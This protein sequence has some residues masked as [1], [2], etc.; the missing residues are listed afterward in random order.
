[1]PRR[2][3]AAEL[4]RSFYDAFNAR[5]PEAIASLLHEDAELITARG[6]RYGRTAAREWAARIPEGELDQRV[7]LE[8][9]REH[10]GTAVALIRRQWRWREGGELADEEE[11]ASVFELR[12][13]LIGRI[14]TG[15]D[16]AAALAEAGIE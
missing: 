15:V 1:V 11:L 6:P 3:G 8:G 13:G 5:D 4:V 10:G 16:R 7:V 9:V 2:V 12:D 14:I